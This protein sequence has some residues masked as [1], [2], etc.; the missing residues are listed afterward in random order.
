MQWDLGDGGQ[1]PGSAEAPCWGSWERGWEGTIASDPVLR[2][3]RAAGL[4]LSEPLEM[5]QE[6][7]CAQSPQTPRLNPMRAAGWANKPART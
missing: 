2:K 1:L 6:G 3:V 7:R 5:G 4:D